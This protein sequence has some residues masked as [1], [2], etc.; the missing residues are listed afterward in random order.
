LIVTIHQPEH[1]PW[2]GFFD[3]IA[4]ADVYVCLDTV[5]FRKNYFQNRNRILTPSG[6]AWLTVPV[7]VKGHLSSTIAETRIAADGRWAK[8][9]WRT[10]TQS[11]GRHPFFDDLAPAFGEV[12]S[13]SWSG[14]R[15][16]NLAL[17]GLFFEALG[18]RRK[19][20]LASDLGVTGQATSL[21]LDIC[22]KLG[23]AVYLSGPMG[24]SYLDETAFQAAG[25]AVQYHRFDH[26]VY[27]QL[28]RD[29]FVDKLSAFDLLMNHGPAGRSFL[30]VL[31]T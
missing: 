2:L 1:L 31:S 5:Q 21:L 28:G 14:L 25:I 22:C 26:P 7:Q 30:P 20:I 6:P 24:E 10:V 13:R 18:L 15:D 4:A 9:Y 8:K 12:L 11:Y 27:P 16:L 19:M 29:D 17:I 23:A 3:K